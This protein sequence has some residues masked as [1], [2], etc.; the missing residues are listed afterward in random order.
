MSAGWRDTTTQEVVAPK[1]GKTR[2]ST[3]GFHLLAVGMSEKR[4]GP[5]HCVVGTAPR[6]QLIVIAL[7]DNA[8]GLHHHYV[9]GIADR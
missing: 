1:N 6:H 3:K 4:S 5:C 8:A 2:S 9:V 7:L